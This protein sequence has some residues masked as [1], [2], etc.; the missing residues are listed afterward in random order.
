MTPDRYEVSPPGT[1]RLTGTL[2]Q[3]GA[4]MGMSSV[5]GFLFGGVFVGA[6]AAIIL[7]GTK[8]IHVDPRS[9]HAPYWVLTVFG[10]SFAAGGLMV[11]SMALRQFA[12][13][14]ARVEATRRYPNE[15]ALADYRWHPDG[16]EV[17]EWRRF[18]T[19]LPWP[20]GLTVF[21]S[22]F[23]WWAFAA[24]G[25]TMVKVITGLFDLITLLMWCM[26]A[27]QLGRALKFGHSRVAFTSFP[28]RPST[29]VILR[30]QPSKGINRINKGTF[31]LRCVA[32]WW[33]RHGAGKDQNNVLIHEELWSAKWVV[34]QPRNFHPKDDVELRYELPANAQPTNLSAEKPI[35]WELE[36][37]LDLPG[38]DFNETYL[39]P[40]YGPSRTASAATSV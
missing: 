38:L 26:A 6:G 28:C 18:A 19:F 22:M 27:R 23:N 12:A 11:W 20:I 4:K 5:G 31:T 9:V 36:V 24:N 8:V 34:D 17:S 13:N 29:P 7:M 10:A 37:K 1:R 35:F 3:R 16:F 39:V 2:Q 40:V 14:R 30:W 21:L 25:P 33:E 15:P 32:E